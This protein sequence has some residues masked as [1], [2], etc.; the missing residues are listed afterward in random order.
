[1]DLKEA[2]KTVLKDGFII[3]NAVDCIFY[4]NGPCGN[5]QEGEIPPYVVC[6]SEDNNVD[7]KE[8]IS[9]DE[10]IKDFLDRTYGTPQD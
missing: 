6:N 2:I 1:M 4:A 8:F 9:E 10:A 3:D 5:W 7:Y